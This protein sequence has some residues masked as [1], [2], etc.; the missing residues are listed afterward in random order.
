MRRLHAEGHAIVAWEHTRI[1]QD[2]FPSPEVTQTLTSAGIPSQAL[3]EALGEREDSGVEDAVITWLKDFGRSHFRHRFRLGPLALWWWAE[4]YLYHQTPLRLVVRDIEALA[5]LVELRRPERIVL[6]E[7]PRQLEEAARRLVP[8]VEV[9]RSGRAERSRYGWSTTFLHA[10]DLAK[11]LGTGIK[12]V[13]RRRPPRFPGAPRVFFLTHASMWRDGR[14]IYFDRILPAVSRETQGAIVVA[15]GPPVP[16]RKRTLRE[17]LRDLFEIQSVARPYR[18]AREY[19]TLSR[20]LRLVPD[21][22]RCWR[23]FS[24]FRSS[25]RG[26]SCRDIPLGS[27]AMACFRDTFLRQFP[28]AIRSYA[29]V[30]S[31]LEAE[32]P[33]VMVLYAESSGLGRVAVA[34]AKA[35]GVPTFA[36]QHGIMYPRYYSHEHRPDEIQGDDGVPI[37]T[38]TAVFGNLAKALL[39]ERGSYPEERILVT[40][41]PKFD[42]LSKTAEAYDAAAT[43]KSLGVPDGTRFLVLATRWTAIAPVFD[44]LLEAFERLRDVE[45]LVK[46]HQ[47]ESAEP[48][49]AAL[50]RRGAG[51]TRLV[52]QTA[53]LLE[54]LV[55]SNGLV[56]VDSLASSEAL[57]LGRPVLVVNLPS[58]LSALVDR[59]VALGVRRGEP[60]EAPLRSFLF[61]PE[62][63]QKLEQRRRTYIQDFAYGA[64]GRSTDRIVAAILETAKSRIIG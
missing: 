56:T 53:G 33:D 36:I 32:N 18:P 54:L 40:G 2:R 9:Y 55:A 14:E 61:D 59:G 47:A 43:R 52:P 19:L 27:T 28:W 24:E 30:E 58:N 64:D 48:Y 8:E 6:I 17:W 13:V 26:L 41:S 20:T 3:A 38:R 29:E 1:V 25:M 10:V 42:A 22:Y 63:R 37:P 57:V 62:T 60:I 44:E 45:L 5:R 35:R 16:F 7:P 15:F 50:S 51:R 39:V 23:L 34:A 4:I 11:M 12:S 21:F 49:E 31:V 46:P